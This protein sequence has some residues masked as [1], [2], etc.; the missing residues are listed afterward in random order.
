MVSFKDLDFR[1]TG[2]SI[3][4]IILFENGYSAFVYFLGFFQGTVV[5]SYELSINK[6]NVEIEFI[7]GLTRSGVT[8]VLKK[9]EKIKV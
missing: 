2:Y 4:S 6:D 5:K 8:K 1:Y 3:E 7:R 9:I